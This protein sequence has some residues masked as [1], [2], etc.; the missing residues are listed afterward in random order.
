VRYVIMAVAGVI[1][2]VNWLNSPS[3]MHTKRN[4][5]ESRDSATSYMPVE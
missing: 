2:L 4:L 1:A 3:G 5:L